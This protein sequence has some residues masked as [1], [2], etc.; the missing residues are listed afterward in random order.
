MERHPYS[1]LNA[2]ATLA[3]LAGLFGAMCPMFWGT[4]GIGASVAFHA[5]CN[6]FASLLA[7]GYGLTS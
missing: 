1:R 2:T 4:G 6:V 7:R 3:F 5:A